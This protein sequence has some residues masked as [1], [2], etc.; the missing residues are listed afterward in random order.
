MSVYLPKP[1]RKKDG[2][3]VPRSAFWQ[4]DFVIGG[5]RYTG[6]TGQRT[7]RAA[8]KYEERLRVEIATGEHERKRKAA[9]EAAALKAIED[10]K[11]DHAAMTLQQAASLWWTDRASRKASAKTDWI[12][13]R[14]VLRLF[15]AQTPIRDIKTATVNEAIQRRR[16]ETHRGKPV[17]EATVNRDIVDTLRPILNHCAELYEDDGLVLPNIRWGRLRLEEPDEIVR[18][19]T[20]E[21]IAAWGSYLDP[22]ARLFLGVALVY[23]PR[24]GELF[25]PPESVIPDSPEGP[26]MLLGRYKGR[27]GWK[28]K[29][30]DKSLLKLR[31]APDH[32]R[33]LAALASRAAAAKL[34]TIWFD[35][36]VKDGRER[37]TEITYWAM[38]H[39][40]RDAATAA[41]VPPG[42]VIHG[43]RHHAGTTLLRETGNL[44]LVRD[45]LGHSDVRTTQRYAHASGA[46]IRAGIDAVSRNSPGVRALLVLDDDKT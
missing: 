42:R 13:I 16:S 29:R 3:E 37:L 31:L 24:F 4:Y 33:V 14:T 28:S 6:S 19:Y 23:G 8:E 43:M 46:D 41:G 20:P 32:A 12:R 34:E 17:S 5:V 1:Q 18:E 27:D 2:A 40:L 22:I 26:Y 30:K 21:Q 38:H 35:V 15:G 9:E 10:A 44:V 36:E 45:L 7:Q 39:R 11:V 25:A